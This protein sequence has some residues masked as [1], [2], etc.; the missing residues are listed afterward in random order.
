MYIIRYNRLKNAIEE[1][2]K[3]VKLIEPI[4]W[5][6]PWPEGLNEW[7]SGFEIRNEVIGISLFTNGAEEKLHYHEKTWEVYQV[8]EGKLKIAVKPYKK[9]E[10]SVVLLN[11]HDMI[12]LAPGILHLVDSKSFHVTQVIQVPPA[13]HDQI[14]TT[15]QYEVDLANKKLNENK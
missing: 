14:V 7:E 13:Y 1:Q 6:P 15:D 10:W 3:K 12:I 5:K 8:L 4:L 11:E 9:G 2:R